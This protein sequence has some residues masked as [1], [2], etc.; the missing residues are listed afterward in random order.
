MRC[1]NCGQEN[2]GEARFCV[3]CGKSIDESGS[4]MFYC[5]SCGKENLRGVSFCA[6]CDA[7]LGAPQGNRG[8]G[9][10]PG[11]QGQQPYGGG[12]YTS[13]IAL[14]IILSIITCGIYWF[15]WQARQMRALNHLLKEQRFSFLLWFLVSIITCFLFNIYYEY[16]MAKA[17]VEIQT[18]QGKAPSNDLPVLSLILSIF[19]L[20][21]ITDAIQQHEINKFFEN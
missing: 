14:D 19:G 13:N 7:S 20:H 16:I 10:P 5:P 11:P 1:S 6:F 18:K 9:N 8:Y 4:G 2:Q 17:V 3:K 21:I 12:P 15:F